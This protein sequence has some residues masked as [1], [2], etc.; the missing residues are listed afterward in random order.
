[1]FKSEGS[2]LQIC[3]QDAV[4]EVIE[5][6]VV[7]VL[8]DPATVRRVGQARTMPRKFKDLMPSS[9]AGLPAHIRAVH[10]IPPSRIPTPAPALPPPIL[11]HVDGSPAPQ[12]PQRT[13]EVETPQVYKTKPDKFGLYRVYTYKPQRDPTNTT[14]EATCDESLPAPPSSLPPRVPSGLKETTSFS[15]PVPYAPFP[16]VTTFNLLY[17]QYDG[18]NNKSNE[19]INILAKV[20]QEPGFNPT[21]LAK[22]DAAREGKRLDTYV[23]DTDGSPLSAR[24]GWVNGSVVIHLPKE[25]VHYASEEAAPAFT[26]TGVY[27]RPLVDVIQN[28]YQQ[29]CIKDWHI[30]P[31]EEYWIPPT[32]ANHSQSPATPS[33]SPSPLTRMLFGGAGSDS[34]S[35][36][37]SSSQSSGSDSIPEGIRV[38]S[39]IYDSDAMLADDA[40]M[41]R[42]PRE[43]GDPDDLEYAIVPW[44]MWTDG[45]HLA[46]FGTASLWPGYG[47]SGSQSKYTRGKPTAFAAHHFV[48]IPSVSAI[49]NT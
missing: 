31:Y 44:L 26:V 37:S 34:D 5:L 41:R 30:I 28:A 46:N 19:Q 33:R 13:P 29:P 3:A 18:S 39:E 22:F 2:H 16:N 10:P 15:P 38:R 9:Y 23:E 40:E 35:S 49:F 4:P 27:Y 6:P 1:M 20:V 42:Q 7:P 45:T 43:A 47:Y 32:D 12:S 24:D 14:W 17:W 8:P 21:D 11:A 36:S 25:K 48:Y